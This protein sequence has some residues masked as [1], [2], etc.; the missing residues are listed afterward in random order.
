[1]STLV[2]QKVKDLLEFLADDDRIR[3]ERKKAK[4]NQNRYQ[5]MGSRGDEFGGGG[6]F[7]D[8]S[9]RRHDYSSEDGY[10]DG[11]A[12]YCQPVFFG[13]CFCWFVPCC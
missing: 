12:V 8:T 10:E 13:S 7:E 6:G 3:D 4:K 11:C 5:G 2:R 1:L 9:Y